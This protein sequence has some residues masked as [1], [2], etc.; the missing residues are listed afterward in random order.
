MCAMSPIRT[1]TAARVLPAVSALALALGIPAA[2]QASTGRGVVLTAGHSAVAVAD[3]AGAVHSYRLSGREPSLRFG[4]LVSYRAS[5]KSA[6]DVR[7]LGTAKSFSFAAPVASQKGHTLELKVGSG[8]LAVS[9]AHSVKVAPGDVVTVK[10]HRAGHAWSATVAVKK[11]ATRTAPPLGPATGA[12]GIITA[13]GADS[14]QFLLSNGASLTAALPSDAVT[15]FTENRVMEPCETTSLVYSQSPTG[16]VLDSLQP[17]GITTSPLVSLPSGGNCESTSDGESDVVGV[18]T[19]LSSSTVT[20]SLA[21]GQQ[22]TWALAPG[23]DLQADE[24]IGD[25][26]DVTYDP[27]NDV[28]YNLESSELYTTGIVT[29]VSYYSITITDAV[30]GQS[31]TFPPDAAAYL[32]IN[33]G[34]RVGIVYWIE[35]GKA[36]ADNASDLTTG[37]SN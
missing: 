6:S 31:E 26:A 3:A 13:I 29:K 10:E 14:V 37:V 9:A 18:I 4:S 5:G 20:F 16:P 1:S 25:L 2:A 12:S 21:N 32:N 28:A 22:V 30:T 27:S 8:R 17:T 15:Y 11:E 19:A 35:G 36:K 24:G 7:S 33:K 23:R 34:D